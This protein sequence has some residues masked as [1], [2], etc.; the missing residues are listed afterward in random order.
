MERGPVKP[1]RLA[2][3]IEATFHDEAERK[4]LVL[5]VTMPEELPEIAGDAVRLEQML[6]NLASNAIKY[7]PAGGRIEVTFKRGG[8]NDLYGGPNND[9]LVGG[10]GEDELFG[11]AGD[12]TLRFGLIGCGGRGSGAAGNA[13]NADKNAKMVAMA[14]VF[15]DKVQESRKRP[16]F[17]IFWRPLGDKRWDYMLRAAGLVALAAIPIAIFVPERI[18]IVWFAVLALPAT[19]PISPVMLPCGT[20]R[21]ISWLAT[22]PP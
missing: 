12:D 1:S 5:R 9:A 20:F 2:E 19:G 3:R 10:P 17:T 8:D 6:E 16:W 7:T 13:M 14:D 11:G 21:L 15:D 4:G 22:T 18:P